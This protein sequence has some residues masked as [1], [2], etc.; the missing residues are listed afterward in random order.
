MKSGCN[1]RQFSSEEAFPNTSILHHRQAIA[2]ASCTPACWEHPPKGECSTI[3]SVYSHRPLPWSRLAMGPAYLKV[4]TERCFL[5]VLKQ[6][7]A[8]SPSW[9]LLLHLRLQ[10]PHPQQ[11]WPLTSYQTTLISFLKTD[12]TW[13]FLY[14]LGINTSYQLYKWFLRA[15]IIFYWCSGYRMT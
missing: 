5:S 12:P 3:H 8:T 7:R 14:V 6:H 13:V 10:S 1:W 15:C 9:E 4:L 11:P 2:T